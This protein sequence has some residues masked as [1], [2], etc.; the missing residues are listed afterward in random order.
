MLT[1]LQL[2][3]LPDTQEWVIQK[4]EMYDTVKDE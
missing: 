2:L 3:W 1:K 4:A